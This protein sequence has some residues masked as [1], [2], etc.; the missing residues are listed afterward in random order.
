MRDTQVLVTGA[1]GFLASALL[2]RVA[3]AWPMAR[4][5]GIGRGAAKG[6]GLHEAV[7]LDLNDLPA[8]DQVIARLRPDIV[9]HLAG[10]LAGDWAAL[11]R[12]NLFATHALLDAL[13]LHA[14]A[15]RIVVV[16]SAA[17]C[18]ILGPGCLP[19][20]EDHPLHPVSAYGASKAAQSLAARSYAFRGLHVLVARVFNI[21]GRGTP[22]DTAL[23]AFAEQLRAI[24]QGRVEP[25]MRVGNLATRRDFVD[26]GDIASAL[27][28]LARQGVAGELYNV[29]SGQSSEIGDLLTRMIV[30][31]GL[32]VRVEAEAMR[33]RPVDVPEVYGSFAK[34]NAACGW[35]PCVTLSDSLLAT[36][37]G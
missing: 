23:G 28:A 16:G 8:L 3:A 33:L 35:A 24:G 22:A 18:G 1:G 25:L 19:V 10:R 36:L 29:C 31:S 20:L 26:V 34:I 21:V 30:L 12:D 27:C 4:V 6:P 17:E 5:T 2:G 9:F 13:S 7:Q 14:P 15:A 11:Y 37:D 32:E